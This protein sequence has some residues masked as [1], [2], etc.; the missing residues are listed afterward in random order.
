MVNSVVPVEN[1]EFIAVDAEVSSLPRPV[2]DKLISPLNVEVVAEALIPNV[3]MESSVLLVE[4]DW[5]D[6]EKFGAVLVADGNVTLDVVIV[7]FVI[8]GGI[9][10]VAT[11]VV[12]GME[13][14]LPKDAL[15]S[16]VEVEADSEAKVDVD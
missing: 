12:T 11:V 14:V 3:D 8:A 7:R 9:D 10:R 16:E 4:N 13:E 15:N 6:V 5:D 2:W 1:V